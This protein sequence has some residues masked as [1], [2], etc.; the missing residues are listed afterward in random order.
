MAVPAH[1]ARDFAFAKKMGLPIQQSIEISC[2]FHEAVW[3]DQYALDGIV[4]ETKQP[5]EESRKSFALQAEKE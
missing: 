2:S 4:I 5:S 3:N 1:D